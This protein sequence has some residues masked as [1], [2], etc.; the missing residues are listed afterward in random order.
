MPFANA[1]SSTEP[2]LHGR[3]A[4][5]WR[6]LFTLTRSGE[7]GRPSLDFEP[8]C[9]RLESAIERQE[10]SEHGCFVRL[11]PFSGSGRRT[12][13]LVMA[14]GLSAS[15]Q[16]K[17]TLIGS[18]KLARDSQHVLRRQSLARMHKSTARPLTR[19]TPCVFT[20]ASRA[21]RDPGL[22]SRAEAVSLMLRAER[23]ERRRHRHDPFRI[24]TN[25]SPGGHRPSQDVQSHFESKHSLP[26]TTQDLE[27]H[28]IS[29]VGRSWR[30]MG[31]TKDRLE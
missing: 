18:R 22:D 9:P 12:Y 1:T 19:I 20:V 13:S 14:K 6:S 16:T 8:S 4:R 30:R 2:S 7:S 27:W 15:R 23:H 28:R 11:A 10:W 17:P 3:A 21:S 26:T 5:R 31:W 25:A 29:N 24:P